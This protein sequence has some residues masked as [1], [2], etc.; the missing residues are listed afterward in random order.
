MERASLK[1]LMAGGPRQVNVFGSKLIFLYSL[2][3]SCSTDIQF[4]CSRGEKVAERGCFG[5]I[6]WGYLIF[7]D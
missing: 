6:V 7:F 5:V 4:P 3:H 1:S 2:G